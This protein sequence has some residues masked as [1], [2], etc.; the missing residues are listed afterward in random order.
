MLARLGINCLTGNLDA[1]ASHLA[2]GC[3]R[4]A[5]GCWLLAGG[6]WRVA[7]GGWRVA[8]GGWLLAVGCWRVIYALGAVKTA[9]C[10][11]LKRRKPLVDG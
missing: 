4:V 2:V 6:G 11:W 3:W 1:I 10:L 7:V 5:V 9:C 8:V